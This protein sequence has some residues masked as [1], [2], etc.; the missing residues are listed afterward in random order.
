LV[1]V[2]VCVGNS[3]LI[4][5]EYVVSSVGVVYIGLNLVNRFGWVQVD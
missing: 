3:S 4:D 5:E 2:E 1:I